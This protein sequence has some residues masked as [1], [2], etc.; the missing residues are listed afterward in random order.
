[1]FNFAETLGAED[2]RELAVRQLNRSLKFRQALSHAVDRK[3]L[4]QSL[5]RGPFTQ[6]YAGGLYPEGPLGD[7]DSVVY[8]GYQPD[9]ARQLLDDLG[10][11][12]TDGDGIRNWTSGPTQ[13]QNVQIALTYKGDYAS[14]ASLGE[15]LISMLG[16]VGIKLLPKPVQTTQADA[17]RD[18]ARYEMA[19]Q[20]TEKDFIVPLQQPDSIAPL[21]SKAPRWHRGSDDH[22]QHLLPDHPGRDAGQW[23]WPGPYRSRAAGGQGPDRCRAWRLC[24]EPLSARIFR[25]PAPAYR[26]P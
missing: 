14:D 9:L 26:Y 10:L 2:D 13:G 7:A 1:M 15:A 8:Y 16:E 20:R 18:A 17:L 25:R 4:G 5:V 24:T 3:A 19:I 12:D 6:E 11:R 21:H 23:H 22:P